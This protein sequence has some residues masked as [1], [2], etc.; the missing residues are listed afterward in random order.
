M[1]KQS[2][3]IILYKYSHPSASRT[4][5]GASATRVGT[6]PRAGEEVLILL[7]H[8]GGPFYS[9]KD[10]GAW[11]IPKGEFNDTETPLEAAK[12]EFKE[13][14]GGDVDGKFLELTPVKQKS[15]KM[16]YV[17]AIE[18]DFDITNFKSNMF[19]MEWPPR[20]GKMQQFPEADKAEWFTFEEASRKIMVGQ[21]AIIEEL[22]DRLIGF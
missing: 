3:G 2:A 22:R 14:T 4:S 20:S 1:K 13:E 9:K 21:R 18:G 12:R 17:F 6:S 7:V 15:G 11:T 10:E 5:P 8:M 16:V 19:E